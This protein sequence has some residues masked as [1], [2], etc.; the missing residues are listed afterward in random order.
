MLIRGVARQTARRHRL[1]EEQGS[2]GR[3]AEANVRNRGLAPAWPAVGR[4]LRVC[5]GSPHQ[6]ITHSLPDKTIT[7]TGHDLTVEQLVEI[8]PHGAKVQLAAAA[9]QSQ[10]DNYGLLREAAAE[11]VGVYWFNRRADDQRDTVM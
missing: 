1:I 4:Q 8:A 5:G 11:D 10:S 6:S 3:C 9:K 7:L 2:H